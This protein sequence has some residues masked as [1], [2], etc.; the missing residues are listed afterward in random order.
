MSGHTTGPISLWRE[1]RYYQT[2]HARSNPEDIVKRNSPINVGRATARLFVD[3]VVALNIDGRIQLYDVCGFSGPLDFDNK[4]FSRGWA[5]YTF[6][7]KCV[8]I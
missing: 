1:K 3:F 6:F 7:K 4:H 2:K 5:K 8:D